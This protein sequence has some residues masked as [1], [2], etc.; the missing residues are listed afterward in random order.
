MTSSF[1]TITFLTMPRSITDNTG[2]SGSFT[3]S[4]IAQIF[5]SVV[6]GVV[7][8]MIFIDNE[9]PLAIWISSLH[10]LQFS[11]DIAEIFCV[12][13]LFSAFLGKASGR[14]FKSGFVKNLLY[15]IFPGG[16]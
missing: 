15:I 12:N 11:K 4:S 8:L 14:H 16:F 9:L 7:V 1:S 5:S 6:Y 10:I 2:T 13:P 3:D